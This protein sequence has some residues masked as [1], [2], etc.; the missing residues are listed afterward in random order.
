MG[1]ITDTVNLYIKDSGVFE[2]RVKEIQSYMEEQTKLT[3]NK[4]MNSYTPKSNYTR[5]GHTEDIIRT[6]YYV[7]G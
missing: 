6:E 2:E 4:G 5:T 1:E 3:L 7:S